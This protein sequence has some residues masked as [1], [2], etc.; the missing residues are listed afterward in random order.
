MEKK[1]NVR[2]ITDKKKNRPKIRFNIWMLIIIF[3]LS[4]AGCFILYMIAANLDEDFFKDDTSTSSQASTDDSAADTTEAAT[5]G[6]TEETTEAAPQAEIIYPVPK[7]ETIDVSYLEN[8]CMITDSTLLDIK[9]YTDFKDVIGGVQLG[10]ASA[11]T[12]KV[13]TNYGNVTVYEALKLK[14]PMNVYLMLGSDLG[15]ASVDEMISSYRTLVSNLTASIP[16]MKIY[17]MQLPPVFAETETV[18]NTLIDEYNSKLLEMAKSCGVYCLD[19]NTDFKANE[20]N[21]KADY[22]SE[23]EGTLKSSYYRD[24]CGF[25]LTHTA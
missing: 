20:G 18:T 24:I 6:T 9:M 3:A 21:L 12:A 25:I 1:K 13:E 17:V 23:E 8:C 5:D 14:K 16:G 15:T 7:S 2:K 19:T 11:N 22:V 10:A 4:F